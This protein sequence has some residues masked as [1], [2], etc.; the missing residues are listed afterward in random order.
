MPAQHRGI[1]ISFSQR[2]REF[3]SLLA[4]SLTEHGSTALMSEH[5]AVAGTDWLATLKDRLKASDAVVL[6]MPT[7]TAISSNSTFFEAGAARAIGKD[8]IVVVPDLEAVDRSNIPFDLARTVVL[9]A[10]KQPIEAVV[11]TVLSA[12]R[13]SH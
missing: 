11:A 7:T 5:G 13:K 4:K 1:F 10:N 2:D 6:V 3:A 12:T 8:V 9:D